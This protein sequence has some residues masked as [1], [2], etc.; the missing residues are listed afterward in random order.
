M[1]DKNEKK[2]ADEIDE[3]LGDYKKQKEKREKNFGRID[4][5][6]PPQNTGKEKD[7]E[8]P[9]EKSKKY[10]AKKDEKTKS[11]GGERTG[12]RFKNLICRVKAFLKSKK[13]K[14]ISVAA[15]AVICA[16]AFALGAYAVIN[17][18][19]TAY[20]RPYEA[21]YPNVNFPDGIREEYCEQYAKVPSTTGYISIEACGY[22][23]YIVQSAAATL[24]VLDFSNS[25]DGL[26][27]NTVVRI[28]AGAC[29][30]ESAFGSAESYLGSAQ[31]ITYSTL[32]EDYE[33]TVVGAFY[34]NKDPQDDNGYVFPYGITKKMTPISF[35]DYA[36]RLYHRFLYET[37]YRF[38]YEGDKLLTIAADSD[39]RENFEFVVVCALNAPAQRAAQP[40]DSVHYPQVWYDEHGESNPYRFSDKWY[41][42]V[43]TDESEEET[44]I[45]SE[46]DYP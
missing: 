19:K 32:F 39:F 26:D 18:Q 23:S 28:P 45:Q 30:L 34:T 5:Q 38:S 11:T 4:I 2:K 31:K 21:E 15:A 44:S 37:D 17:Y 33:F 8:T 13:G 3:L 9:A 1:S 36:D 42:T 22:E 16:A 29:D 46:K 27:F 41:P 12:K 20:L 25:S 43:Y 14:K 24:P 6:K 10:K 40:N 35:N 7:T